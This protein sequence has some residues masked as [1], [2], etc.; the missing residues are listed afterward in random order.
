[1]VDKKKYDLVILDMDGVIL[2]SDL[3]YFEIAKKI[4]SKV[5]QI[6]LSSSISQGGQVLFKSIFGDNYTEEN[7]IWFREM[8]IKFFNP[9]I[10]LYNDIVDIIMDISRKYKLA[11][12]SNKPI[13]CIEGIL[14]QVCVHDQFDVII[15]RDSGLAIKPEPDGI[16]HVIQSI[17]SDKSRVI[18]LG[19]SISDYNACNKADITFAHCKY[20]FDA[21]SIKCEYILNETNQIKSILKL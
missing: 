11:M 8:Q 13:F 4:N 14:K 10:H 19:D 6:K 3:L 17:G 1:M 12:V 18:Y 9:N 2:K 7:I 21:S 16:N 20:G 15:G 5:N